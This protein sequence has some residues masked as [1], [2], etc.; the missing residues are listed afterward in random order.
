VIS[1][2]ES[3]SLIFE[4]GADFTALVEDAD[5]RLAATASLFGNVVRMVAVSPEHRESG[6]SAVAISSLIEASR[7]AGISHLFLYAK[8]DAAF[9]FASLGF[10]NIAETDAVSL[11]EIGEPGIGAYRRYLAEN[12]VNTSDGEKIGAIVANCNPFTLGHRYLIE[13]ALDRC[14]VLYVIVVEANL[15]CFSFAD[16]FAMV[17]D[18]IADLGASGALKVIGSGEYA[19]S[20]ATFPTY[21]LKDRAESQISRQQAK[22]DINLFIRLFVPALG[23]DAR[24]FG[25]EPSSP[26]TAIYNGVMLGALPEAGIEAIEI[27]RKRTPDGGVISAS[28]ARDMLT[29]GDTA[30]LGLYLPES[31]ISY[32]RERRFI[33]RGQK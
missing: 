16:R 9:H 15:S 19:V 30:E 25:N 26:V 32:L 12:R 17:K 1:L 5:G 20:A 3:Q 2:I 23:L 33:E 24:F 4:E 8:P 21:F 6:L 29:A 28:K 22:L 7:A 10:R 13:R 14:D 27:E 18:G 31:T 11:L